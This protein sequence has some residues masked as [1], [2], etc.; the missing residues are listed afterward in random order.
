MALIQGR[1]YVL[2]QDV[3]SQ[4]VD[5]IAHRLVMTFDAVADGVDPRAVVER[6]VQAIPQ[7]RPVWTGSGSTPE[8]A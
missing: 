5:V 2:P 3:A 7:P 6:V 4:A 8:F 1:D